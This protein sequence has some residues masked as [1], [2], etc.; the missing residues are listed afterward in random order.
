MAYLTW[1]YP[2]FILKTFHSIACYTCSSVQ[3]TN[4][5]G[6]NRS[7]Q[8]NKN[9]SVSDKWEGCKCCTQLRENG[10]ICLWNSDVGCDFVMYECKLL[11]SPN[12]RLVL[13]KIKK[14]GQRSKVGNRVKKAGLKSNYSQSKFWLRS[15]VVCVLFS[16]PRTGRGL[17]VTRSDL[18]KKNR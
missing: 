14:R 5:D 17:N 1:R 2:T 18:F 8:Y 3:W 11:F 7:D 4:I 10:F 12:W 13:S 6:N 16:Q 9:H 15:F